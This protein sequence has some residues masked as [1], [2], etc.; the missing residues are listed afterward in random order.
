MLFIVSI[1]GNIAILLKKREDFKTK[2]FKIFTYIIIIYM[3]VA[4]NSSK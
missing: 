3:D 2:Y 1:M 4:M